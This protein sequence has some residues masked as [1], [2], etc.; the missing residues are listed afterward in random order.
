MAEPAPPVQ[1][2]TGGP[3]PSWSA[4]AIAGLAAA[5]IAVGVSIGYLRIDLV[6]PLVI[7]G[8]IALAVRRG[9]AAP[10]APLALAIG[11]HAGFVVWFLVR[12]IQ[13]H[14]FYE[15]V[16]PIAVVTFGILWLTWTRMVHSAVLL[17]AFDVLL[18]GFNVWQLVAA[19][20]GSAVH[21]AQAAHF[22]LHALGLAA[23]VVGAR[24]SWQ[25]A[26]PP[27][28]VRRKHGSTVLGRLRGD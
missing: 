23:L 21:R 27:K 25:I 24:R 11:L 3:A 7:A 9:G 19:P 2:E 14:T 10:L 28:R 20:F 15:V 8:G 12:A 1:P 13:A 22:V 4:G 6:A 16:G 5:A 18:L 26:A 17:G